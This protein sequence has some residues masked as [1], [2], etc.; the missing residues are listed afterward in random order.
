MRFHARCIRCPPTSCTRC[1]A[2]YPT[3]TPPP[4]SASSSCP[5]DVPLILF[6]TPHV[7]G[8]VP[9]LIYH[10]SMI[11][12]RLCMSQRPSVPTPPPFASTTAPLSIA[13]FTAFKLSFIVR[14]VCTIRLTVYPVSR[15]PR[16]EYPEA[17]EVRKVQTIYQAFPSFQFY[18]G[19][20]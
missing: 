10:N 5:N 14:F 16:R 6:L 12:D 18:H 15:E 17:N 20:G 19:G 8:L 4:T 3:N 9:V 11:S 13:A 1:W 7:S 2:S